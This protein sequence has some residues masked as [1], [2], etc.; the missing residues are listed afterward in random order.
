MKILLAID[1]SS[2]SEAVVREAASRPWPLGTIFCVMSVVDIWTLEETPSLMEPTER[3]TK[4]VVADAVDTLRHSG[5][6]AFGEIP[7]GVPKQEIRNYA[8]TWNADLILIGS[9]QRS[10]IERLFAGSIA[11]AVLRTA[12]CSVEIVRQHSFAVPHEGMRLLLATDGSQ[13]SKRAACSVAQRPWPTGTQ[14]KI[15]SVH[16]F[17]VPAGST[18][19]LS[20]YS[21]YSEP[22]L[23]E[24]TEATRKLAENA[25]AETKTMI[26]SAGLAI[27]NG[28]QRVPVGDPRSVLLDEAE[29]C[30]ADLIVVGSHGKHGLDRLVL[31]SVSES[32]AMHARCSVEVVRGSTT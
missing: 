30:E 5:Y 13:F 7:R 11:Q 31:G 15:V 4:R 24:V 2:A 27:S 23:T 9:R 17:L 32:V 1:S 3:E 18:A 16:E 26:E 29:S 25:V 12:P 21:I 20:P 28:S 22:A 6:D 10:D 8:A 14:V 19:A